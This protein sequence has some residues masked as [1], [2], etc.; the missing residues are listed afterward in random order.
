VVSGT[1][2]PGI[3]LAAATG[4]LSGIPAQD[5]AFPLTVRGDAASRSGFGT[6]TITVTEPT[7]VV[8]AAATHLLGGAPVDSVQQRFLDLQGNQNGKFDIGDF[9]AYLRAIGQLP[10]LQALINKEQP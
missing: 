1:L 5:G 3:T 7:V 9:R 4:V 10:L 8:Q 2:P 6:F